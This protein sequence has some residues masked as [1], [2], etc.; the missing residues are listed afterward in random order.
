MS[1]LTQR[2]QKVHEYL[3]KR[4]KRLK[5]TLDAAKKQVDEHPSYHAAVTLQLA[6]EDYK[7]V[8]RKV[9]I[10]GGKKDETGKH[11]DLRAH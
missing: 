2:Q 7:R 6:R 5:A 10:K 4:I 3:L 9:L 1:H 11:E 8:C